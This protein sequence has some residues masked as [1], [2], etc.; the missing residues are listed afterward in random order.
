MD[1][2][3]ITIKEQTWKQLTLWKLKRGFESMDKLFQS[4]IKLIKAHK[5]EEELK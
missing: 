2:K 3:T 1:K 4:M 5:M